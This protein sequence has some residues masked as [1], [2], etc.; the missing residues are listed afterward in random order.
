[1]IL[2]IF[3]VLLENSGFYGLFKIWPKTQVF[4]IFLKNRY[5]SLAILLKKAYIII[6][7]T[8]IGQQQ[9]CEQILRISDVLENFPGNYGSLEIAIFIKNAI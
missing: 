9:V 7:W 1:M 5:Q 4:H 2:K 6:F 8:Y 3:L